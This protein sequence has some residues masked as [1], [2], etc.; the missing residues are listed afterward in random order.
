MELFPTGTKVTREGLNM[1][2]RHT[3]NMIR[4]GPGIRM[5]PTGDGGVC[6]GA[7]IDS[8][9]QNQGGLMGGG[10]AF[11][12]EDAAKIYCG[13]V[14]S[15]DAGGNLIN[16]YLYDYD[17]DAWEV[18]ITQIYKPFVL[19]YS[20]W[21]GVTITYTDGTSRTYNATSLNKRYQ[22]RATWGIYTEIQ[23]ITEPYYAGE[24]LWLVKTQDGNYIDINQAG[25]SWAA[26]VS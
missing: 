25:R 18:S 11:N 4:P 2:P 3:L 21:N 19:M 22:R 24:Y 20:T 9:R 17:T 16:V 1:I 12:P 8:A 10:A 26:E 13:K 14:Q 23:Y 6:I 5:F 15:L 7:Y